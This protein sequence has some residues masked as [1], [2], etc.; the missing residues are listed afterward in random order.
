MV[1][2][3]GG[4]AEQSP[5][6]FVKQS[7]SDDL[8]PPVQSPGKRTP[9][10]LQGTRDYS[11]KRPGRQCVRSSFHPDCRVDLPLQTVDNRA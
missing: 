11:K 6:W 8:V 9:A 1:S 3:G 2:A 7:R 10:T 5:R 4:T